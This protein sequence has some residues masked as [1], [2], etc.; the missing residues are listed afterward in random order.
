MIVPSRD[1]WDDS[2]VKVGMV[3]ECGEEHFKNIYVFI[4]NLVPTLLLYIR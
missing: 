1:M 3:I 2:A 4:V